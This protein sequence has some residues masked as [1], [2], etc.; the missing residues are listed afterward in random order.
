MFGGKYDSFATEIDVGGT[1]S[2][3]EVNAVLLGIGGFVT[4]HPQHKENAV[5]EKLLNEAGKGL[6]L[7]RFCSCG[8]D[9]T[10]I[11]EKR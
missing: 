8:F 2:E 4:N 1:S 3:G 10:I 11:L 9:I 5:S 7:I 6:I